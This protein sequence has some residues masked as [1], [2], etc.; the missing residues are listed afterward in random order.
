MLFRK[1]TF[2]PPDLP[3]IPTTARQYS[4]NG[5]TGNI[6]V[7]AHPW[8]GTVISASASFL[9]GDIPVED[10]LCASFFSVVQWEC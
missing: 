4:G 7:V 8:M 6:H 5:C 3:Q 10:C 2:L 9:C 1:L